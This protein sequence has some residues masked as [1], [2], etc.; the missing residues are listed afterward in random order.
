MK[1]PDRASPSDNRGVFFDESSVDS[2]PNRESTDTTIIDIMPINKQNN[3][4]DLTTMMKKIAIEGKAPCK[5]AYEHEAVYFQDSHHNKMVAIRVRLPSALLDTHSNISLKMR[6][7]QQYLCITNEVNPYF[8]G[9]A[10]TEAMLGP[11]LNTEGREWEN[12]KHQQ[13]DVLK[14]LRKQHGKCTAGG[15]EEEEM[16]DNKPIMSCFEIKLDF[17]CDDIFDTSVRSY[18]KTGHQFIRMLVPGITNKKRDIEILT[19]V[20]VVLVSK[21]KVISKQARST[22]VKRDHIGLIENC[23]SDSEDEVL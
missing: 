23:E 10:V 17:V 5:V 7:N 18:P 12:Y 15:I 19:L 16:G 6:G 21:V 22:P 3:P 2:P 14:G 13:E 1:T 9:K 20:S 8:F 4:D 11:I